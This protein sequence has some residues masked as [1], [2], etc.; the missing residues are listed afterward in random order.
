[1]R[2]APIAQHMICCMEAREITDSMVD[3]RVK[4]LQ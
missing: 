4:M 2:L 1:M 3:V